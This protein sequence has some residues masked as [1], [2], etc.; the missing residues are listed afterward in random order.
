MGFKVGDEVMVTTPIWKGKC[1]IIE[2]GRNSN[3]MFV[4]RDNGWA[5]IIYKRW[6]SALP[7]KGQQLLFE[8]MD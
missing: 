2:M 1:R 3:V 6:A 7:S 8:F 4:R 5:E